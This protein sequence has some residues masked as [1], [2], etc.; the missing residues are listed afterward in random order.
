MNNSLEVILP[1]GIAQIHHKILKNFIRKRVLERSAISTNN[2]YVKDK[3]G[4]IIPVNLVIQPILNSSKGL[5]FIG[6]L[7][8]KHKIIFQ[9]EAYPVHEVFTLITNG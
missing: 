7:K 3:K 9:D 2:I 5:I 8:P 1:K 6:L 4:F